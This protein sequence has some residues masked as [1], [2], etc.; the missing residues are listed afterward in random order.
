MS[1]EMVL[2]ITPDG[3]GHALFDEKIDLTTLGPLHIERA[4]SVEFDEEAQYWRVRDRDGFALFNSPS[5]QVCLDWE[6]KYFSNPD[7]LIEHAGS[8]D[9]NQST[10][11]GDYG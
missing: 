9:S 4:T 11:G 2:V 3:T 1:P 10:K 6:R 8:G 7:R 5:R